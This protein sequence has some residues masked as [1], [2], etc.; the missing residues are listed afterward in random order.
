LIVTHAGVNQGTPRH[1][2]GTRRYTHTHTYKKHMT[3]HMQNGN[4][5]KLT[6]SFSATT[7][8]QMQMLCL[9]F[10]V[11]LKC[12]IKFTLL[13]VEINPVLF[14]LCPRLYAKMYV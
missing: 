12:I 5:L 2:I 3:Q 13:Y 6:A 9:V 11:L 10:Y 14:M 7:Q 8:V 1:A 4:Q